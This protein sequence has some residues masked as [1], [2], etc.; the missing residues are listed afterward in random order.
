MIGPL[1]FRRRTEINPADIMALHKNGAVCRHRPLS[2]GNIAEARGKG[3]V[4]GKE[5]LWKSKVS[6][7]TASGSMG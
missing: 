4:E 1:E 5:K 6:D 3:W 2:D 7:S